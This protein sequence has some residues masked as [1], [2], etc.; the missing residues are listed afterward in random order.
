MPLATTSH[1]TNHKSAPE[2][3]PTTCHVAPPRRAGTI[4]LPT[5]S[6]H[7]T[8]LRRTLPAHAGRITPR[9]GIPAN[10]TSV[11]SHLPPPR[12]TPSGMCWRKGHEGQADIG[13]HRSH[14]HPPQELNG[15]P[16]PTAPC[17][18]TEHV[19]EGPRGTQGSHPHQHHQSPCA[20]IG[21]H[22]PPPPTAHHE[23]PTRTHITG[24]THYTPWTSEPLPVGNR[25]TPPHT[26]P[27]ITPPQ[28]APPP[29]TL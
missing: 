2:C 14:P 5:P 25:T 29:L 15:A 21:S 1:T 24:S 20:A 10:T 28:T 6:T 7:H 26:R 13:E 19:L 3:S 11:H 9:T 27:S 12:S 16:C 18:T 4:P 22:P 23:N 8:H 17:T